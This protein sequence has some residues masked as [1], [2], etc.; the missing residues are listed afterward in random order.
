M[1]DAN[2]RPIICLPVE[3]LG[4]KGPRLAIYFL[5]N[6]AVPHTYLAE[7]ALKM[8]F[9]VEDSALIGQSKVNIWGT[10]LIVS[11]SKGDW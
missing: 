4:T 9:G 8:L 7:E 10:K 3:P 11:P 2:G 1:Y 6:T 5:V